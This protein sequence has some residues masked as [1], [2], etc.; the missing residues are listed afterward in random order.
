MSG[1]SLQRR[2][3]KRHYDLLN[4]EDYAMGVQVAREI[5]AKNKA[6][7]LKI[8]LDSMELEIVTVTPNYGTPKRVILQCKDNIL[9]IEATKIPEDILNQILN[10]LSSAELTIG[11]L[12]KHVGAFSSILLEL[13]Q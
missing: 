7:G 12:A 3:P 9:Y 6:I 1:Q 10:N 11:V 2:A 4:Q 5:Y 8:Y 13:T